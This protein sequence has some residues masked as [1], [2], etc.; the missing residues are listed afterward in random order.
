[1]AFLPCFRNTFGRVFVS[2][3]L[4]SEVDVGTA[5]WEL[6]ADFGLPSR[7]R[8]AVLRAPARQQ[9]QVRLL[10]FGWAL[11]GVDMRRKCMTGSSMLDP[12]GLIIIGGLR[13]S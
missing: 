9:P 5:G 11:A 7:H 12:A 2:G 13:M 1:M 4:Q 6:A 3:W 8:R 10:P